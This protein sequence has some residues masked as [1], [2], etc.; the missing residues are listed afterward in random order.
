MPMSVQEQ[1]QIQ[2]MIDAASKEERREMCENAEATLSQI[3]MIMGQKVLSK[4]ESKAT[5]VAIEILMRVEA[6]EKGKGWWFRAKRRVQLTQMY[7]G[8]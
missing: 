7:L 3:N 8:S 6:T 4:E 5:D 1:Q 2:M